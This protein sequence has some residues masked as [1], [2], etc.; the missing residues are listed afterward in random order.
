MTIYPVYGEHVYVAV[1]DDGPRVACAD[2]LNFRIAA[3]PIAVALA[4]LLFVAITV[5]D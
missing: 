4:E 1:D 2:P 5:I 3:I